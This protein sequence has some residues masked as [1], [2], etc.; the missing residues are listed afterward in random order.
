MT[1][2]EALDFL[3]SLELF[4]V[5]L[6]LNNITRFLNRLG[7]PQKSFKGIH[8]AGTNG[9]GSVAS[10]FESVL[11]EAGYKVGKFT[12]PHLYNFRERFHIDKQKVDETFVAEFIEEHQEYIRDSRTTFF[13]TCT[14]LAFELFRRNKVEYAVVEVGLGGRLDATS[15]IEPELTVITKIAK[16]HTKTLGDSIAKIAFEK[17]GIIKQGVPL[18]TS[19]ADP[20]ALQV[21]REVSESKKA[22]LYCLLP[23]SMVEVMSLTVEKMRFNF[24]ENSVP[25]KNYVGNLVGTHQAENYGLALL[26]LKVLSQRGL[27]IPEDAYQS[28]IANVFWPAR[29]QFVPGKPNLLL[30]CAHNPD[31][32][33]ALV[34]NVEAIYPGRKFVLI[35]GMLRRPDFPEIFEEIKKISNKVILTIPDHERAPEPEVLAR[36][37]IES[38]LNFKLIPNVIDAYKFAREL[39]S[40]NEILLV[41]GSHFTLGEIMK[42]ENIPT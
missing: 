26:G 12:S 19:V 18:V 27:R 39:V 2:K 7:N 32:V 41:T 9:K 14:A 17:C 3:Y 22:P 16:D 5:K 30:D 13:E 31:G 24:S 29:L 37:A 6:G 20:E 21:I 25:P 28:G 11:H 34:K 10:M 4:G 8:V 36:E 1:Y 15:L 42:F 40:D 33:R 38:R 23:A 35:L